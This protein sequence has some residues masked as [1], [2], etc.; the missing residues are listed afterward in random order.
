[1]KERQVKTLLEEH[2]LSLVSII[3]NKHVKCKALRP[4]G[5]LTTVTLPGTPSDPRTMLNVRRQLREAAAP[6][7]L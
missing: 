7:K 6:R 3:R 2:G 4:D 5:S 1:M